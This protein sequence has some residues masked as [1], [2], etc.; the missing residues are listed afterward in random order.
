MFN[1]VVAL[2]KFIQTYDKS[3]KKF[4]RNKVPKYVSTRWNTLNICVEFILEH[5]ELVNQFIQET[6][7]SNKTEY[8]V[9]MIKYQTGKIKSPPAPPLDPPFNKIPQ[10]WKQYNQ[11]LAV[12][13]QFTNVVE[14]DL[15]FLQ[16]MYIAAKEAE[17]KLQEQ[18]NQNNPVARVLLE[19]FLN[20]FMETADITLAQLAYVLT[21]KGLYD[22]RGRSKEEK[23][24]MKEK[25]K[26]RFLKCAEV[27]DKI[28]SPSVM[29]LPSLFSDYL[30]Y[31]KMLPGENPIDYF[32]NLPRRYRI[33]YFHNLSMMADQLNAIFSQHFALLY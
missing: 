19:K 11:P 14:A 5:E 31:Q 29:Y 22:Y 1:E 2:F 9:K 17:A 8:E 32:H 7:T 21:P 16:D 6:V 13:T 27:I 30:D 26:E 10:T 25:L 12:I 23:I 24:E 3:F 15:A 18:M 33:D 28:P 4:C 20:R